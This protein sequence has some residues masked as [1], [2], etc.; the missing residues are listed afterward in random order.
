M[1]G[2]GDVD[3]ADWKLHTKYKN[4]YNINHQVIQWFW[5]VLWSFLGFLFCLFFNLKPVAKLLPFSCVVYRVI[6]R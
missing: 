2:L 1:C 3:V 4:G 5:K 6:H